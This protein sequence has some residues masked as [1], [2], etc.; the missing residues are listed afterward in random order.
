MGKHQKN[1]RDTRK[2][3][4]NEPHHG[5]SRPE[6]HPSYVSPT[7]PSVEEEWGDG[8]GRSW[9][10]SVALPGSIV[11]NAQS[12]ELRT[13]LVGQIGRALAVFNI[14]E[15]VVYDDCAQLD[16]AGKPLEGEFRGA[17]KRSSSEANVFMARL[18]Q[19]LETPQYLRRE[20]FPVHKDL[21][22][23]GLLNPLDC[24]HHLRARAVSR[25]REAVVLDRPIK[26]GE[27]SLVNAGMRNEVRIDRALKP[28]VRV[29]VE[30]SKA[31]RDPFS[32][33]PKGIVVSP[34]VPRK[35][36]GVY[37]GYRT[38]IA[39][40]IGKVFSECPFDG[41]YDCTMGT[42]ERGRNI[43]EVTAE[44]APFKHLLIVFGGLAGIETA[45]D[46]DQQIT[47][48][49]EDAGSMFTYWVNTC[50]RQG[51]RTIR[52]EEAILITMS[53][54]RPAILAKGQSN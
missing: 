10:V 26:P 16:T 24:P 41:G 23:A 9:T 11:D 31:T 30:L 45:V 51:S 52:T 44:L 6:H 25:W 8:I 46:A 39:G 27:G 4:R 48:P 43:D 5:K 29:T 53:T 14:D 7:G 21:Q 15:V 3:R 40:S 38:R 18:L 54:L 42:S 32:A 36:A 2:P 50:P 35:T 34:K 1:S 20:L 19:Y 12:V 13:Y 22:Y 47:C 49:G 28:G 33:Y 37:W 17:G